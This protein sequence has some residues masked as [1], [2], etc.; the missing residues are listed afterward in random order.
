ML[1]TCK[2]LFFASREKCCIFYEQSCTTGDIITALD[3]ACT[4]LQY[5]NTL[6]PEQVRKDVLI[7]FHLCGDLMQPLHVGYGS[8]K[9]GNNYQVQYNGKGTNL[10]QIWDTDI[11]EIQGI[12]LTSLQDTSK[13]PSAA[14]SEKLWKQPIDFIAWMNKSR[15]LLPAVYDFTGYKLDEAYMQKNKAVVKKQLR[16]GGTL[17]AAWNNFL[18]RLRT[19]RQHCPQPTSNQQMAGKWYR[20]PVNYYGRA[21]A[22]PYR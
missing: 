7:L 5:R 1:N 17:L 16:N 14:D 10:H 9:G 3:E 18:A 6:S 4:D 13:T 20:Q 15:S 22:K 21:T 19:C 2:V 11:I 12:T 8:D